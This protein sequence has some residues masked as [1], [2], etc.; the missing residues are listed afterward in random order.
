MDRKITVRRETDDDD[1][2]P[3]TIDD[4]TKKKMLADLQEYKDKLASTKA[5]LSAHE[6]EAYHSR[7]AHKEIER[8]ICS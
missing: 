5:A 4:E 1:G 3:E 6:K 2:G 8:K 7:R